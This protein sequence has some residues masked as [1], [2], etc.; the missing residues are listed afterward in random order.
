M[1]SC[2]GSNCGACSACSSS[3][4]T[5]YIHLDKKE[6]QSYEQRIRKLE[7]ELKTQKVV[8]KELINSIRDY[9]SER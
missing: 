7:E 3:V 1:P 4:K 9:D 8:N 6:K 5:E 2:D